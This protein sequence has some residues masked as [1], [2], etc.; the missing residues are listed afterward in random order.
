M[1]ISLTQITEIV[2]FG[3]MPQLHLPAFEYITPKMMV[4]PLSDGSLRISHFQAGQEDRQVRTASDLRSVLEGIAEVGGTYGNW[5]SFIRHSSEKGYL[6]E[7]IAMNPVPQAGRTFDRAQQPQ[8][9][10]GEEFFQSTMGAT[11][12]PPVVWYNP[13]TWLN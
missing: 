4:Q 3:E 1:A 12:P 7:P 10:P 2:I 11:P 8:L 5:V 13:M 9:E 6:T